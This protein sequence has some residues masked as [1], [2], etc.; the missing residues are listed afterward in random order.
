MDSTAGGPARSGHAAIDRFLEDGYDRVRGM[1]SHFAAAICGHVLR[2]QTEV[3]VHGDFVEI[4]TFEGRF[5]IALALGLEPGEI[6]IGIDL[7]NWP[8]EG[9]L[10][11]FTANC[12]AHGL[13]RE[14]F[15]P[16]KASSRDITPESLRAKLASGSARFIH[17]D[18]EHD[19]DNLG[20][21]LELALS[22]L[23]PKGIIALDDMLHP[24]Y[25]MLLLAVFDFLK[26]H[27]EMAVLCIVD[28]ENISA[29]AKFLICRA[30]AVPLYE[31]DLMDTFA[32]FHFIVGSDVM[33]RLTLV[34]STQ[35]SDVDVG[36]NT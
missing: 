19:C 35:L 29:A 24:A 8:N 2:R 33:G 25:P 32:R 22:V 3:E 30:D 36:W 21:D 16:W 5:F 15:T 13:A 23:H 7:F 31:Q 18:G 12:A 1:S 34:L 4:G 27:P 17:I 11:R 9:L 26:R 28:R 10:D 20:A 6:G 14:R